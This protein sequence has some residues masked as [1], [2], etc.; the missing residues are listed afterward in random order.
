MPVAVLEGDSP[1]QKQ[2]EIQRRCCTD[3]NRKPSLFC[4]SHNLACPLVV[5]RAH[6][7]VFVRQTSLQDEAEQAL[8]L[9]LIC[10]FE[11][12][13][14]GQSYVQSETGERGQYLTTLNQYI[15]NLFKALGLPVVQAPG[16]AEATCAA[17]QRRGIVSACATKDSDALIFGATKVIHTIN[18]QA[19][20]LSFLPSTEL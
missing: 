2:A 5:A 13:G 3:F 15:A 7:S 10:R 17:L 19:R 6:A 11:A 18:L 4:L 12:R 16:E 1:L 9:L 14:L 8:T 20:A